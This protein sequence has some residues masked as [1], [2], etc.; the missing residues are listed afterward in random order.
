M[1]VQLHTDVYRRRGSPRS[2]LLER[3]S[4]RRRLCGERKKKVRKRREQGGK[5]K[6]TRAR[7]TLREKRE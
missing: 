4:R 3:G 1:N 2:L 6:K 5:C 7:S